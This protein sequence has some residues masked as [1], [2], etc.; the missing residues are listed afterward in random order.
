MPHLT[1]F[2]VQKTMERGRDR[3]N[4]SFAPNSFQMPDMQKQLEF[5]HKIDELHHE[6]FRECFKGLR[7]NGWG[8]SGPEFHAYLFKENSEF[9]QSDYFYKGPLDFIHLTSIPNLFSILNG[10]AFRMF[11]LD[12]S[13]DEEEYGYA[14]KVLGLSA[15]RIAIAKRF[16]FTLSFCPSTELHNKHVWEV[17]GGNY[18]KAAIV[19]SIENDP[20]T[21]D[22]YHIAQVKY[23]GIEAFESYGERVKKIE[24]T[25]GVSVWC[26]V[27]PLIG[28]HKEAKWADEKEVRI[29]TYYPYD[30]Y[31][32]YLKYAKSDYRLKTGRNRVT[33][34]IELPLWVDNDSSWIQSPGKPDLDRTQ[35]LSKGFFREHPKIK[36]KRIIIG[37]NSGLSL[38]EYSQLEQTVFQ[39]CRDRLGYDVEVDLNMY[40][41]E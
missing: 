3:T 38:L 9:A 31:D 20:M 15:E 25:Y 36:V 2:L 41:G 19:F 26:D 5:F 24:Q 10:T 37:A 22:N 18:S 34:Y 27:S 16:S 33:N 30:T 29:S 4:R 1:R 6:A 8:N 7:F 21:W 39:T 14:G 35:R 13:D 11:N 12:S 40:G 32:A 17:Y 28:F 23:A